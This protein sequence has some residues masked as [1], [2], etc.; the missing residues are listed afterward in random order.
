[1][2]LF[3]H[4]IIALSGLVFTTYLYIFPSRLKLYISYSLVAL[5][6]IS[7][8]YLIWLYPSHALSATESGLTYLGIMSIA[9]GLSQKKLAKMA[10]VSQQRDDST[11]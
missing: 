5:T 8:I 1:M 7:G 3:T 2:V 6:L 11:K 4:I 10:K 9:I